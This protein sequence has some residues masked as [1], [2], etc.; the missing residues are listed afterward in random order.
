MRL[1]DIIRTPKVLEEKTLPQLHRQ[2]DGAFPN[3]TPNSN[4]VRLKRKMYSKPG[5]GVLLIRAIIQGI[6]QDYETSIQFNKLNFTNPND[7]QAIKVGNYYIQPIKLNNNNVQVSCQCK[8]FRWSFAWYN[9]GDKALIGNPP[10]P[11]VPI[12]NRGPRNPTKVSGMCK[13]LICLQK[14]LESEMLFEN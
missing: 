14:N 2:T 11:Y 5:N 1:T 13:H 12:S 7:P 10:P 6:E 9:S 3:R 8:D 4:E